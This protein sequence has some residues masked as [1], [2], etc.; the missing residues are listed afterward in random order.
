MKLPLDEGSIPSGPI[1]K[2][3]KGKKRKMDKKIFAAIATLTGTIIGAG[4]L[5]IPYVVSKSGLLIGLAY[6][7]LIGMIMIFVRFCFGEVILRTKGNHMLAGYADIYLGKIGKLFALFSVFFGVYSALTAYLIAEGESLSFLIF[8]STNYSLYLGIVF[9]ICLAF[10]SYEGLRAL[11]KFESLSLILVLV[12]IA[13]IA[14]IFFPKVS[15][16]S[17]SYVNYENLFVPFGVILFSLLGTVILPEVRRLLTGREHE[18]KKA[19]WIGGI[20]PII[21]YALFA[22]VVVGSITN[23]SEIATLSLGRIFVV[24]GIITMFTAYFGL[25]ISIRD[26]FRFDFG[27]GRFKGWML[28]CLLPLIFFLLI[29]IFNLASFTEILGIAGMLGGGIEILIILLMF[30]R[31][32]KLGSRK[33]EY[34]IRGSIIMILLILA[35]Y[36]LGITSKLFFR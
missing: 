6:I 14:F 36:L 10:L 7:I 28:A 2:E 19:L 22:I 26:I 15:M 12:I 11:K 16:E 27:M 17:L 13:V 5:G 8:G 32:K 9:W 23:I 4:F 31:A 35:F 25:T 3:R 20:I 30:E 33:P 34:I 18:M 21:V 1:I 24:L 29:K